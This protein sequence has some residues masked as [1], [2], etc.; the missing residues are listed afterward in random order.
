M[1]TQILFALLA[2]LTLSTA[3]ISP[4][5]LPPPVT[6]E[7]IAQS[8]AARYGI[9]FDSYWATIECE[10]PTLDPSQQSFVPDP[11]GPNARE[12]SWGLAQIDLDYHPDITR[13]QAEDPYFAT[14]YMARLF[15]LGDQSSFHAYRIVKM[16]RYCVKSE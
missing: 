5:P 10:D 13:A 16:G 1:T 12:N 15:S 2:S 9:P 14:D 4:T 8:A 3:H 6:I 11:A 7:Q